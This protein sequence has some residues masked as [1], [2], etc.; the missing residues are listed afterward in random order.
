MEPPLKE[1]LLYA[2]FF[3]FG[4][5]CICIFLLKLN[6]WGVVTLGSGHPAS[7][8]NF[9]QEIMGLPVRS[10]QCGERCCYSLQQPL[11]CARHC[12]RPGLSHC[13]SQPANPSGADRCLSFFVHQLSKCFEIILHWHILSGF[14]SSLL[15][16]SCL[17][18]WLQ[19]AWWW[20]RLMLSLQRALFSAKRLSHLMSMYN[21]RAS[22]L[23]IQK[24]FFFFFFYLCDNTTGLF[25]PTFP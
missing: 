18:P 13:V 22:S 24:V 15:L 20:I 10:L 25:W 7:K 9:Q 4:F 17:N 21:S 11:P 6:L 12:Q 23:D 16:M 1:V 2:F 8:L 5:T 14:H 3:K 19:P